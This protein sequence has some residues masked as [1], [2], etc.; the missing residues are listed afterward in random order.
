MLFVL[1]VKNS[2]KYYK[3]IINIFSFNINIAMFK[4]TIYKS[5]SKLVK[6]NNN[7]SIKGK[8]IISTIHSNIKLPEIYNCNNSKLFRINNFKINGKIT[9]KTIKTIDYK[10]LSCD[11]KKN[12][13]EFNNVDDNSDRQ[14]WIITQDEEFNDVFYIRCAF[15]RYNFTQ[16]LGSPNKNN[17]VFLYT[18]KN[19]YTKW[20]IKHIQDD[21]YLIDYVGEKFNKEELSIII[22]RYNE[23]IEWVSPYNDVA[24]IYNKGEDLNISFNNLK[25]IKNV[26]R[27]GGTYL[28]HIIT[29]Y[30]NLTNKVI[31]LQG[32]PF[33]HNE[34]V[35]FGVDNYEKTLDLQPLGLQYIKQFNIPPNDILEK[36]K[37]K[38]SYGLEYM[39]IYVNKDLDYCDPYYFEDL[40]I[41]RAKDSY[42]KMFPN[43]IS[44]MDNFLERSN[45]PL[46]LTTESVP[47][48]WSGLFSVIG[49]K[50][51]KFDISVYEN[52][53][54]EL[55]SYN[56]Q[57][58]E[59]GYILERL[60]LYIF[61]ACDTITD[62]NDNI[63]DAND[64][65]PD[66]NDNI[67][68]ANDNI[69]DAN[70]NIPDAND[71]ITDANDN[72]PDC[73]DATITDCDAISSAS[74]DIL[75]KSD[76]F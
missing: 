21:I 52:L 38:T 61:T 60:W 51:Q 30:N 54:K 25:N 50:I 42:N 22:S 11:K 63:P 57:G 24:I 2:I 65:I 19:K 73:T 29:N 14:K 10:F 31:F 13:V 72:I 58:G 16:Y 70:D 36:Y 69:P 28:Y 15:N 53:F 27:E 23:D 40:G 7:N 75:E 34:T 41:K 64:N 49:E 3:N 47:F 37:N 68:D 18:S 9:I 45:F 56:S 55:I 43:C 12:L 1:F 5:S 46:K 74:D 20:S 6:T 26:G 8:S 59:N 39:N 62:A 76:G 44:L 66:A 48:T 32:E 4:K 71:N 67:T 35:L 17:Q 33:T